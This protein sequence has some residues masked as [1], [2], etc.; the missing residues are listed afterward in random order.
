MGLVKLPK[1]NKAEIDQLVKEQFLCRIA[2]QNEGAP[3]FAPFQYVCIDGALYFHFTDYGKKMA[4]LDEGNLVCVEIERYTSD[5]SQYCFAVFVGKLCVVTDPQ[6]KTHA[7]A[8]MVENAAA[9]GLSRNFLL[10]H[11]YPK[12]SD[13][14]SLKADDSLVFVKLVDVSKI[15]G[16]KSP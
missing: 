12:D 7:I 14:S 9:R 8:K 3:H 2:F 16:L 6:E 15:S 5:L 13:W 1:M 4:L 10:A 11:G